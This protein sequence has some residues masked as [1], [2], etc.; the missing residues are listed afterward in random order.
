MAN[1]RLYATIPGHYSFDGFY[2]DVE[3]T[4]SSGSCVT[5]A[6]DGG[7]GDKV[8]IEGTSLATDGKT[9]TGGTITKV[10]FQNADGDLYAVVD[11]LNLRATKLEED[12]FGKLDVHSMDYVLLD[13]DDVIHGSMGRDFPNGR[14]G[15]DR[16]FGSGGKDYFWGDYG[17]D[18]FT[19]GGGHDRFYIGPHAGPSF[20]HDVI[21]DFHVSGPDRDYLMAENTDFTIT[22]SGKH[23][24]LITYNDGKNDISTLLIN[25]DHR[26]ISTDDFLIVI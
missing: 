17:N 26:D 7:D 15:N 2:G 9:M 23:D 16:I 12:Q 10:T 5:F 19:G 14:T 6:T 4:S 22:K 11:D 20:G 8:I 3:L 18:T 1:V 25:V 21:T 24:T 13:G